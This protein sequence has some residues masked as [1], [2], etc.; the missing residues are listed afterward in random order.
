MAEN[1]L[2]C[3]GCGVAKTETLEEA[4]AAHGI[5]LQD[6]LEMLNDELTCL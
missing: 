1:G 6:M 3:I 4:C 2:H 5:N